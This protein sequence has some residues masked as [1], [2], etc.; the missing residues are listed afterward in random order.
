MSKPKEYRVSFKP[1]DPLQYDYIVK[2]KNEDEAY[3]AGVYRLIEAIGFDASK[4][5]EWSKTEE[6][7]DE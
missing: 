5:W 7:N 2:A 1:Y 6:V 4:D 3:D